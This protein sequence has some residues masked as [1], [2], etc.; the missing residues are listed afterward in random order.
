V[1][2]A[3]IGR[4]VAPLFPARPGD[5][6]MTTD[7]TELLA[8]KKE[9]FDAATEITTKA[10]A[11][12]RYDLTGDENKRWE[13]HMA[14]VDKIDAFITK[15]TR[16]AALTEST[17]R[18]SEQ[19]L[20]TE[21]RGSS[22]SRSFSGKLTEHDRCEGFR[23]WSL[24]GINKHNLTAN[25]IEI[26]ARCGLSPDMKAMTLYMGPK[27]KATGVVPETN[28]RVATA[29][30]I[31]SWDRQVE[32]ERA[33]LTGGQ[34]TTTTGGYT[35]S[36][37]T[38][39]ALEVAML[40]YGGIRQVATTLRTDTGGPL[41]IPTSDDTSNKGEI[42]AE[43]TTYNE[44]EMTF[45]QLVLDAYKYSSKYIKASV[46]FLQDTSINAAEFIGGAL[47]VRIARITS[48]HF[49]TGT[50][51]S[52]P[53]GIVTAATSSAVTFAT[54]TTVTYDNLVDLIH[55]V[56]PA[57]RVNG[58]LMFHDGAL[59]MI[60][61]VKVLQYSGD[62]TGQ[63]LWQPGLTLG[64][65]NTIHGY[66]YVINQSMTTPATTVKSILFGDFSKYLIRDV[67]EVTLM[68]L[69]ERFA[70]LGQVAFL[71]FSRHDGDLLDAGTHPVKYGVQA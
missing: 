32:E 17:G 5:S 51:S 13:D 43:N 53:N 33:A 41:P 26:A 52:Q 61:K 50:G 3:L 35:T 8:K 1:D 67:R 12:N 16:Q 36:D 28:V 68:R 21:T 34:S 59:K 23:A 24:G 31:R 10:K 37:A 20:A 54:A 60:K 46:E 69:D 22:A 14:E 40:A 30:D 18:R 38:M 58:R 65:P 39:R 27:M 11:D 63:P 29:D 7:T 25:Q 70:E 56:D 45:G 66:D 44:L 71:A 48:D 42:I 64:Q 49:T 62:T 2:N 47:G 4:L 19:Q 55:S 15:L 9:H 6:P 57:Y